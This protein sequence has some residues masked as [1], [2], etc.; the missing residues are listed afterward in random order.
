M[1]EVNRI[2]I[3]V[4]VVAAFVFSAIYYSLLSKQLQAARGKGAK[5]PAMTFSTV[6]IEVV[7]TFITALF[8]AY[9]LVN[10]RGP[11]EAAV[12]VFWLWLAFPVVLLTGS[13]IHEGTSVKLAIIHAFDWLVKLSIFGAIFVLWR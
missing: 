9:A 3:L 13:V 6:L 7:R 1:F 8:M 11:V 4:A 2:A 5:A 10:V 12:M